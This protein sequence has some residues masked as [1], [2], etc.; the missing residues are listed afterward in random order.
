MDAT[1]V[2]NGSGT[3][4]SATTEAEA[5]VKGFVEGWRAP[6]GPEAAA[7]HFESLLDPDVRLIQPQM[8]DLVG[9]A[10]ERT[11]FFEPLFTLLPDAHAIVE[12]WAARGDTVFI[13]LTMNGTLGGRP[14][15]FRACDRITLRNGVAIER[16]T[17]ADPVPLLA[18]I[19]RRPRAWPAFARYQLALLR[20]RRQHRQ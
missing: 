3:N 4:E 1:A 20:H 12:R 14:V 6:A 2:T 16:E 11:G 18:T 7:D 5:W 15:S 19:A 8:P 13:E 17:Y 9:H 10:E